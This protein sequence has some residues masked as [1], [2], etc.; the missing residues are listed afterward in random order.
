MPTQQLKGQTKMIWIEEAVTIAAISLFC[1]CV[2]V[3]AVIL[4]GAI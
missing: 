2:F 3:W 1:A 4:N